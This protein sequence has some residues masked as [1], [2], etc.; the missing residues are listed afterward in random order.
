MSRAR[1]IVP[2]ASRTLDERA[3]GARAWARGWVVWSPRGKV[4]LLG[5]G[6][7]VIGK[8]DGG[9]PLGDASCE[10]TRIVRG[11]GDARIVHVVQRLFHQVGRR[12]M[13]R[14][15]LALGPEMDLRIDD[16]DSAPFP[17]DD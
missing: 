17:I 13:R 10:G 16:H 6:L 4:T 7:E 12:A 8:V 14:Q 15:G 9:E 1:T 3:F 5:A 2:V 11:A